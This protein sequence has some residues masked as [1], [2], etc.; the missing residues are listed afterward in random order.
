MSASR[1][2]A[3]RD[4][5]RLLEGVIDSIDRMLVG[6]VKLSHGFVPACGEA[7]VV[8]RLR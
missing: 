7:V 3:C 6:D 2:A 5:Q 4:E 1:L 8:C